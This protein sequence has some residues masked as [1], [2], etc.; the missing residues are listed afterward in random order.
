MKGASGLE[1]YDISRT[2]RKG[3]SVWPGDPQ[4]ERWRSLSLEE[5]ASCNAS[6]FR[7]SAHTGTHI[8]APLHLDAAGTDVAGIALQSLI[9]SARVCSVAAEECIQAADLQPLDWKGV[10]RILLKTR[11]SKPPGD[12][13]DRGYIHL[14]PD[15]SEFLADQG[16][17]LVGTDAPS[18][19]PFDSQDLPAHK[20]LL[21]NG[22]VILEEAL[23]CA[24]PPG[25]YQ[26]LCL[27]LKLDGSDGSPVRAILTRKQCTA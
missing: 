5:G 1:I 12:V 15:A 20:I 13:F 7:M 17:L 25:D 21:R 3:I 27:P 19:D 14:A 8:D 23:L 2:I 24:V 11:G 6:A 22:I 9:G 10:R 16:V 26:L 4:F 18:V